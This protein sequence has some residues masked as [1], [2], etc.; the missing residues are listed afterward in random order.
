MY[1]RLAIG[2]RRGST[3]FFGS[4]EVGSLGTLGPAGPILFTAAAA[5][6][7]IS[8]PASARATPAPLVSFLLPD[9]IVTAPPPP[10]P[11]SPPSPATPSGSARGSIRT[12]RRFFEGFIG[13][14]PT[15]APPAAAGH[16]P[17][18]P[19]CPGRG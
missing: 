16:A 9:P 11:P 2:R 15:A 8:G 12:T 4:R 17:R 3:F 5:L 13:G 19:P 14:P 10:P 1:G 7:G 18:F 6:V